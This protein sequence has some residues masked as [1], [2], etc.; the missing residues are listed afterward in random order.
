MI[1]PRSCDTFEHCALPTR[2]YTIYEGPS[3][4]YTMRNQLCSPDPIQQKYALS[5]NIDT[6]GLQWHK[7]ILCR[8]IEFWQLIGSSLCNNYSMK[9]EHW[10][11]ILIKSRTKICSILV[12]KE[13]FSFIFKYTD[14]WVIFKGKFRLE[15]L[16]MEWHENFIYQSS[17][18]V[19]SLWNFF[20][21]AYPRSIFTNLWRK[22]LL[23]PLTMERD[24]KISISACESP[25][26]VS[27]LVPGKY[28]AKS[29]P[30]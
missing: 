11:L 5:P 13:T 16:T 1:Q 8:Y 19:G 10:Q 2:L 30:I 23:R 22:V 15:L 17:Q 12:T 26:D 29:N 20:E 21:H 28:P 25:S 6:I 9:I 7:T 4:Y 24:M 3:K 14:V 27:V 18:Q